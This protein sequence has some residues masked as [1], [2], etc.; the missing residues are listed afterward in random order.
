MS[1]FSIFFLEQLAKKIQKEELAISVKPNHYN[2]TDILNFL[3]K[4]EITIVYGD[5]KKYITD[6]CISFDDAKEYLEKKEIHVSSV[7]PE[8]SS[9]SDKNYNYLVG[10]IFYSIGLMFYNSILSGKMSKEQFNL[11][12][13]Q[14]LGTTGFYESICE[15]FSPLRCQF[16]VLEMLLPRDTFEK[17]LAQNVFFKGNEMFYDLPAT[18]KYF[19][20]DY[21]DVL[22]RSKYLHIL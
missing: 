21:V 7:N 4:Y 1:G 19:N 11:L 8:T 14:V 9:L 10:Q 16:F 2:Y 5:K 20:M 22:T 6:Y 12:E 15:D 3:N 13:S 17:N 18:A